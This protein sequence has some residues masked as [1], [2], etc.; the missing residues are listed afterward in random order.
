[1]Q[2]V[3]LRQLQGRLRLSAMLHGSSGRLQWLAG[4][5]LVH[6]LGPGPDRLLAATSMTSSLPHQPV[7]RRE[8]K[9]SEHDFP[10]KSVW[11]LIQET[12][13]R[14][15][16]RVALGIKRE[17]VWVKWTYRQYLQDISAV[18]KA[19]LKLGLKQHHA[20]CILGFNSPEWFIS[21]IAAVVAGGLATGIYTTNSPQAVQ[22]V[23]KHSRA[24]IMVVAD[25]EQL[26]KVLEVREQLDDLVAIV[27]YSGEVREAG[28]LSWQQ[29]LELGRAEGE[30][31]LEERLRDQAVNQACMLVYTSGTTGNPKAAMISQDNLTWTVEVAKRQYGWREDQ[32]ES[33]TYLPLSHIAGQFID[34]FIPYLA[35]G[36]VWFAD[37]DALKGSL[38][39]TLVEVRPTR[40]LGVPRVWEKIQERLLEVGKQN[41]GLK[42]NVA[43]WAKSAAFSHHE[44]RMAGR[45]GNS[46]SYRV[47]RKLVLGRVHAALGLERA[48][49][50][51]G[52]IYSSAAPLSVQTFQYF[53][54]TGRVR[55]S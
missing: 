24:N 13:S 31:G 40:F 25:E 18:A 52:G 4:C 23:A 5:R 41:K 14:C 9:H 6:S 15:P 47:A 54:V 26:E 53:Q 49:G 30:E 50:P 42:K 29:L 33:V 1:M 12:P 10:V 45:P 8:V 19:F 32:E 34:I 20:V 48:C 43:D 46:W 16:D 37:K 7:V 36:T 44:E 35:G 2:A 21:D 27:Q 28:V 38:V 51:H 11:S 39:N 3:L 22:Y 55:S 17:G